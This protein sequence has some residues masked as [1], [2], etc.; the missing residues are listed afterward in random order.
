MAPLAAGV[1]TALKFQKRT[2]CVGPFPPNN[3]TSNG[4]RRGAASPISTTGGKLELNFA[5]YA[6]ISRRYC[7]ERGIAW[8]ASCWDA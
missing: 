4:I 8:T 3:G 6:E 2:P 7:R 5:Q 1:R